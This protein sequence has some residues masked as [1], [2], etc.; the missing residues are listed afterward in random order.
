ML[1]GS[2][3]ARGE[4]VLASKSHTENHATSGTLAYSDWEFPNGLNILTA[5]GNSSLLAADLT[6]PFGASQNFLYYDQNNKLHAGWFI[7]K[8]PSVKNGLITNGGRTIRFDIK[9]GMRWSNG[10]EIVAKDYVFG[11]KVE[12]NAS[13]GPA[14]LGTC[15]AIASI[16]TKGKYTFIYHM[17]HVYPVLANLS[18]WALPHTWSKLGNGNVAL[19]AKEI[20][21]DTSFNYEDS[22]YVTAG[23]YQVQSYVQNDRI[24]F[25]PMKY[26]HGPGG[27]YLKSIIFSFYSSKPGM[28]EAAAAHQTD[29]TQDYTL[30]DLAQ[31]TPHKSAYS[32]QNVPSY[33]V[34]QLAFNVYSKTFNGQ[35]NPL[36]NL[37][38]RQALALAIDKVG[39]MRSALGVSKK[40]AEG[41]V[42]Y[43]PLVVSKALVQ[44][45]GDRSLTGSWDPIAHKY[46][47]YSPK[48]VADAKKLLSETPYAKGFTLQF[49]TTSGNPVRQA[50]YAV[51]ER[52]WSAIGVSSQFNG[53]PASTLFTTWDKNGV[54]A[55]GA[56]QV[57]MFAYEGA[58]DPDGLKVYMEGSFVPE[59]SHTAIGSNDSG[60][61][62][63]V[64]DNAFKTQAST[65]DKKVRTAAWKTIQI[66]MNKQAYWVP[67]FSRPA[68]A[69]VDPKAGNVHETGVLPGVTWNG[70]A[71]HAMS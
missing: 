54:L 11:W 19:A 63:P 12:M 22:S 50:Q 16:S 24:Q 71:W 15:D 64:I 69:T 29:I 13:T 62:D 42:V 58:P 45:F 68:I 14:C 27:P 8:L 41:D 52:N 9:P 2:L 70:N 4:P 21:T 40:V 39:M 38:V 65:F 20:G 33:T 18:I 31:L 49:Y 23:P 67:L 17:K 61:Q 51:I 46:L 60:I 6:G 36:T 5:G 3:L 26:F 43:G 53:V 30:A 59:I 1:A 55:R 48:S 37:K 66:E 7:K 32:I 47:A 56:F 25:T 10:Q 28:I 34:E 44:P 35:P 57:G